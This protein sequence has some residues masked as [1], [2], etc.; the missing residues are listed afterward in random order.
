[1]ALDK[2]LDEFVDSNGDPVV[3]I[4]KSKR[5]YQKIISDLGRTSPSSVVTLYEID[6]ENLLIDEAMAYNADGDRSGESVFRFHNN[7][8]LTKQKIY[9]KGQTYHPLPIQVDGFESS[10]KGAQPT[11]RM[12]LM[13]NEESDTLFRDFKAMVRKLDDLI[14]AKVTRVRTFSKYLDAENF[15]DISD[16]GV[17]TSLGDDV[18]IPEGVE[19]DPLAE[20][21]REIFF[22]NRK[23]TEGKM[24]LE[25][26]L[27][28]FIDF[29]NLK[30]PSRIVVSRYCQFQYRGEGCLYDYEEIVPDDKNKLYDGFG[31]DSKPLLDFPSKAPPLADENDELFKDS[32]SDYNPTSTPTKYSAALS[33]SAGNQVYLIKNNI[34]YYFVATTTVPKGEDEP[35]AIPPNNNYW[36]SDKCSKTVRGC[37]LRWSDTYKKSEKVFGANTAN[38]ID[39]NGYSVS[40]THSDC[41]AFG[42]F[43]AV[44]KLEGQ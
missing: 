11:P 33:Y 15:Y 21:P 29:E 3:D 26:E 31:C 16:S 12:A 18:V 9:W 17:K 19:P 2:K 1:M 35:L 41:L 5:S 42:G 20:F 38:L 34:R 27:A 43:P 25:F 44:E 40:N 22:I 4:T 8:K 23:S 14:G 37:K 28:S 30:L 36:V 13:S 7:L 39:N 24:G 6:L 10:T 32:V